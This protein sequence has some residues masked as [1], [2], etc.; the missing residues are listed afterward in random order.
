M[1]SRVL[2]APNLHVM[3]LVIVAMTLLSGP[4]NAVW[5]DLGGNEPVTVTVLE[6]DGSRS[7]IEVTVGGF[8]AKAVDIEG[9]QY[10]LIDLPREGIQ[11]EVGLPQLPNV[12]R[13][14]IIPDDRAMGL[15][16]LEAEYVD[17]P[18][19]PVAPSKG[20]L[21]RTV[22][23]ASVAYTFADFYNGTDLY[24]SAIAE[25]DDPHILRDYRGMVVDANVFRYDPQAR[26]LRVYTRLVIEV[27]PVG[28]GRINV[29]ERPTN[30]THMDRQFAG[31]YENHFL[32]YAKDT[33]YAPLGEDGSLLII[34]YPAYAA[35]MLPLVEW[36][37]Q[38]GMPTRLVT[39]SETGSTYSQIFSYIQNEYQT[40]DLAYVLLVGDG[41]HVPKYGSDSDP[42][43]SLLAGSDSYPEIFV[44][45][46]S[47]E[48]PEHVMTQVARTIAY[49]RD[50]PAGSGTDWLQKGTGIASDQGPGHF[51]EYD[52]VHMGYIRDDL[53]GY[54]YDQVDQIYDPGA[55][56]SQVA[57]AVN[58]GRGIMNYVG[59]GSQ[60]AWSTSGFSSTNVNSLTNV[61]KFPFILSVACNNGTFTNGTCFG[62]SWLRATSGGNPTGAIA[63]YMSFISQSWDPPMYA[64]DEAVDLLIADE[65][66]TIGGLWFN[67]S[68]EMMDAT[69]TS[70]AN[71]FRNWMI[72]GDPSVSVRT[73]TAQEMAVNHSGVVFIGSNQFEV[74]VPG[75]EG[76]L[77]AL[78][79]DGQLYGTGLTDAGGYAAITMAN[80]PA[81]PMDITLTV[82]A[83]NRA[84]IVQTLTVISPSVV[85]I[86]PSILPAGVPTEVMVTVMESDGVTPIP[87]VEIQLTDAMTYGSSATTD[88]YGQASL[89]VDYPYGTELEVVGTHITTGFLFDGGVTVTAA[90]LESPDLTVLTDLVT[91]GIFVLNLPSTLNSVTGTPEVTVRAYVPGIGFV[92]SAT[93]VLD[94]T[95]TAAGEVTAWILKEGFDLYSEVFPIAT[96]P[97]VHGTVTLNGEGDHSGVLVTA[98]PGGYSTV[99]AVD[100]TWHLMNLA[101]GTFQITASKEGWSSGHSEIT[102]GDGDHLTGLDFELSVVY[103]ANVC[104][105]ANLAIPDPPDSE[106]NSV[107]TCVEGGTIDWVRVY[108]DISHDWIGNLEIE[109]TSPGGTTVLLHD[110]SGGHSSDIVGW[111]P[112]GLTPASGLNAFIGEDIFGD[113]TLTIRDYAYGMTGVLNEWCLEIGYAPSTSAADDRDLPRQL[114]LEAN[115][116]NPFNPMTTIAFALP[117]TTQV[118][119]RV[120]D[121]SGKLVTTLAEETLSAGQHEVIWTGR[122]D[123]GRQAAS[124]MYFYRLVAEGQT[125]VGKMLML[126]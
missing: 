28:P 19:L 22:D 5:R 68:C 69:G 33:R 47:A 100:G 72:F 88:A 65:K 55:S 103:A 13:S 98:E 54:G 71:E 12:R 21:P 27:A 92:E 76:A 25:S 10:Y 111:Y 114:V 89:M 43:Y 41:Q 39:L 4:A 20:F 45:R 6:D 115:Y 85:T 82:S 3:V 34:A 87:G 125:L 37:N 52:N 91:E 106:V 77:C 48:S 93:G 105:Q 66:R 58:A 80:P 62:E 15:T 117:K 83:F 42:A 120:Y 24:P 50:T 107:Q 94:I 67:G 53:L 40:T 11:K 70:G 116:P 18:D 78:Y 26:S 73:K 44:G 119:L 64:Q 79:A 29:L 61:G 36:K 101:A 96:E 74:E 118:Q 23:P 8:E 99:S 109:L 56:S 123:T 75:V 16:V 1:N 14:L 86:E 102:V 113:W 38:K 121:L 32:N 63:T 49:E 30:L 108:V 126:K 46:F 95:P 81:A 7:V 104:L 122:D 51:N 110:Q 9:E 35:S 90:P 60:N 2:F 59:H 124:G 17:I 84:T 57:S 31:V 112:D 97:S